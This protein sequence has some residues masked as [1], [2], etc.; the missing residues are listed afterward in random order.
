VQT[1]LALKRAVE[2]IGYLREEIQCAYNFSEMIG[3]SPSLL[4]VLERIKRVAPTDATVLITGESGTGKELAARAIHNLSSRRAQPLVKVNCGAIAPTLVESELFGHEKGAFTGAHDRRTGR[5]ELA[6]GGTIFLDEVAELPPDSQVKILRV[7]QEQEF[8]RVGSSH[9]LKVNVRVIAA[10][11]RDLA[12]AVRERTFRED[13][14]YRLHV[15]PLHMPPL[16][17]RRDDIELLVNHFLERY[18]KKFGKRF[19]G[20]SRKM[21]EQVRAY[22]WPGNVR[23]LQNVVERSAILTE[24]PLLALEDPLRSPLQ[25]QTTSSLL[26]EDVERHHILRVLKDTRGIIEGAEGAAALLGLPAS[27]L[28]SRM[29]K[30]GISRNQDG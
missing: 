14:F 19:D 1:H 20:M 21:A 28:R 29:Q 17:E 22:S 15:V 6:D 13:L 26:L 3:Q 16:R 10:T 11:N 9:A 4:D 25:E 8:E 24:G 7:L 30:L 23:E 12:A 5:F 2:Q 18:N 27:T